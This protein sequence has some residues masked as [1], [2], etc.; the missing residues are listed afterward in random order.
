[1]GTSQIQGKFLSWA[2]Y[3]RKEGSERENN[4]GVR[5]WFFSS[6]V[7]WFGERDK[8]DWSVKQRYT[9]YSTELC[10]YAYIYSMARSCLT[11]PLTYHCVIFILRALIGTHIDTLLCRRGW[12]VVWLSWAG[13]V[14]GYCNITRISLLDIV[15]H[16]EVYHHK[17]LLGKKEHGFMW[18]YWYRRP[19]HCDWSGDWFFAWVN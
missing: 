13:L 3:A 1:M 12:S 8:A 2:C 9:G 7:R 11:S 17:K 6:A 16:C 4:H 10:L 14:F 19:R 15:W 5:R 18:E